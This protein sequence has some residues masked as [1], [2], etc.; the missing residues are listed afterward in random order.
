MKSKIFYLFIFMF[1]NRIL[2]FVFLPALLKFSPLL[3][4]ILSPFLHHLVLASTQVSPLPFLVVG[5][6]V[7]LFQCTVGYEFGRRFGDMSFEWCKKYDLISTSKI[8]LVLKW[9]RISAPMVLFLFPGPL[10]A[11]VTGVSQL[12]PKIFFFLMIPS[13]ILWIS[14]C[15]ILGS[16]LEDYIVLIKA[17]L[18]E[19]WVVLTLVFIT[20]KVLHS[21]W[22][23]K[24]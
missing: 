6:G 1:L 23:N 8:N 17:F 11:M 16:L 9:L 20:L 5:I 14:A 18:V 7:S 22:K 4:I 21:W 24:K 15:L 2:G 12:S 10:I 19:H 3:L 13:Q